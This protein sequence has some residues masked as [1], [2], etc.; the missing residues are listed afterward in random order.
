VPEPAFYLHELSDE[1]WRAYQNTGALPPWA[2]QR[3][4][5][6]HKERLLALARTRTVHTPT[7]DMDEDCFCPATD[8]QIERSFDAYR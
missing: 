3:I 5:T 8:E 4:R 1:E 7:C 6:A 2:E